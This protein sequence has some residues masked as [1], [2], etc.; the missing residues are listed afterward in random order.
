MLP[1]WVTAAGALLLAGGGPSAR[2]SAQESRAAAQATLYAFLAPGA[3]P[4]PEAARRILEFIRAEKG[5][6]RLRPVLLLADYRLLVELTPDDPL[7]MALKTLGAPGPLDIPLHDP[8][9]LVLAERW[10]ITS[11][12]ALALVRGGRAHRAIGGTADPARLM[13]CAR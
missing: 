7:A 5:E 13:G 9:G 10:K 6:V 2:A 12:P 1:R 8:E 3:A 11:L 4:T